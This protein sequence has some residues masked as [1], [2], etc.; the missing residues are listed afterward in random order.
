MS[1]SLLFFSFF[2]LFFI[3]AFHPELNGTNIDDWVSMERIYEFNGAFFDRRERKNKKK[4]VGFPHRSLSPDG[5]TNKSF[6]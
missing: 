5:W 2:F 1:T 6:V 4:N 3:S